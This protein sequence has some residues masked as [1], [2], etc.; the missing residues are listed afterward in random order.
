MLKEK[1]KKNSFLHDNQN[2]QKINSLDGLALNK[3][4][5][6]ERKAYTNSKQSL[7]EKNHIQIVY[8]YIAD[9]KLKK[10]IS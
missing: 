4:F 3:S 8:I 10:S 2:L 7:R 1:R 6:K 5:G 9:C